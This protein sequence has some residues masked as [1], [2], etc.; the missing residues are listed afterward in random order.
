MVQEPVATARAGRK[1]AVTLDVLLAAAAELA[2]DSGL[3]SVSFRALGEKLGV[4]PMAVHRATGG[5]DA[6]RHALV[7]GLVEEAIASIRWPEEW[8]G[9]VSTFAYGLRDL[10]LR[11]PLVLEAHRTASL[12]APGADDVA[13]R[14]VAALTSAGLGPEQAAYGYA[15]LHDF[16]TG[17]VSIRLGRGELELLEVAPDRRDASVFAEHHDY[18]RRF[19]TGLAILIAGLESLA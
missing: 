8:Q 5:I 4:S 12:D 11:H 3:E 13:H 16:V 15:A 1:P 6:L 19:E 7:A 9:V 18:D 17:H 2:D 10:L 14:V